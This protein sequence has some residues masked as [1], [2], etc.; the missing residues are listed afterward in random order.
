M[1]CFTARRRRARCHRA[2]RRA[3]SNFSAS[4]VYIMVNATH[5]KWPNPQLW[6]YQSFAELNDAETIHL[7]TSAAAHSGCSASQG[8]AEVYTWRCLYNIIR[9]HII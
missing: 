3:T 2:P 5:Q 6:D 1:L 7:L 4:F 9:Y 8:A